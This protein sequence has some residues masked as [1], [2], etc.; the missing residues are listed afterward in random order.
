MSFNPTITPSEFN[1]HFESGVSVGDNTEGPFR[2]YRPN[3]AKKRDSEEHILIG[4]AIQQSVLETSWD[5]VPFGRTLTPSW[6][7]GY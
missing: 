3:G 5:F 4:G 2:L 1:V 7:G 6:G